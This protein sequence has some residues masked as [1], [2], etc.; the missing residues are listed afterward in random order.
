M[1][2]RY[3][4]CSGKARV[5]GG[6][7]L[8]ASQTYPP[9]FGRALVAV[10]SNHM[11]ELRKSAATLISNANVSVDAPNNPWRDAKLNGVLESPMGRTKS[12]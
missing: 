1:A 2:T 4:D 5:C 3:V 11:A 9:D 7:G 10:Y 8:K 12:S 6:V